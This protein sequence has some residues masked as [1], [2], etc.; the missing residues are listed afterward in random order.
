M[1][2]SRDSFILS[3]V[4]VYGSENAVF[5]KIFSFLHRAIKE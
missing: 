1:G 2:I 4:S 3:C 5:E